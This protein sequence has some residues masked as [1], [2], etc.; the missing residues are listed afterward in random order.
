MR[1]KCKQSNK[2]RKLGEPSSHTWQELKT[3]CSSDRQRS[4][5]ALRA[6]NY[7]TTDGYHVRRAEL[8]L[9]RLE[10]KVTHRLPAGFDGETAI[11]VATMAMTMPLA[12]LE[13]I[14]A[15][16][17]A[18]AK[19]AVYVFMTER[20]TQRVSRLN[21]FRVGIFRKQNT[22]SVVTFPTNTQGIEEE[23]TRFLGK[24]NSN[25][26]PVLMWNPHRVTFENNIC[27][28]DEREDHGFEPLTHA[29]CGILGI[30]Y[31]LLFDVELNSS[32]HIRRIEQACQMVIDHLKL[33]TQRLHRSPGAGAHVEKCPGRKAVG[34]TVLPENFFENNP[35]IVII[36]SANGRNGHWRDRRFSSF[37]LI[38][39]PSKKL[40]YSADT[41]YCYV[42]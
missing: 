25:C 37:Y 5:D 32:V 21:I 36:D 16:Q 30:D 14:S 39:A 26:N 18:E 34:L 27:P 12:E 23:S 31:F 3:Y 6:Q 11:E 28:Y 1:Q 42:L 13:G 17:Y 2:K 35:D 8:R 40:T 20:Q 7:R 4:L 10:L 33:G 22:H 41:I 38:K 29:D 9:E 15:L 19:G 24:I